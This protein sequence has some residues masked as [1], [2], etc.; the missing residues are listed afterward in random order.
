M[1]IT[2]AG[3]ITAANVA[4]QTDMM[5]QLNTLGLELSTGQVATTYSGL[6]SQ[7]GLTLSLNAQLAAINGYNTA[8]SNVGTTLS[9]AQ[10]ALT[11]LGDAQ[12]SVQAAVSDQSAFS[13]EFHGA[14]I[15][16]GIRGRL[17]RSDR[18]GAEQPGRQ[19]LH[20]LRQ[21]DGSAG[22]RSDE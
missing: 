2:G 8:A 11:Q 5:N 13:L 3:S 16:A 20:L 22:R 9:I 14:D 18:G 7:A 19:Q 10:S 15:D 6:A 12:T 1:S 17:S 4:A 21:C